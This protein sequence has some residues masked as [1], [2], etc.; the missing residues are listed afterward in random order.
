MEGF[1]QTYQD[2][3]VNLAD[4]DPAERAQALG[5]EYRSGRLIKFHRLDDR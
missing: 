5:L 4:I 3:L 2:L 1:E